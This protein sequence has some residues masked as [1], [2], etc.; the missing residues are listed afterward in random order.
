MN[1]GARDQ[2]ACN[3][4]AIRISF[5]MVLVAI[6]DFLVLLCPSAVGVLLGKFVDVLIL[7][8]LVR[9]AALFDG[10]VFLAGI[11]LARSVNEGSVYD[12]SFFGNPLLLE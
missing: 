9:D 11:T 12:G 7:F 4:L 2:I 6:V 1:I 5:Y 3:Q 8:P 10:F